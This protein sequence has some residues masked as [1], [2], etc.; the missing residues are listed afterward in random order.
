MNYKEILDSTRQQANP[1]REQHAFSKQRERA[2]ELDLCL[3]TG[4]RW[5]FPYSYKTAI[6]FDLSGTIMIYFTTHVVTIRG[7][8]LKPLYEALITHTLI[9]V[10]EATDEFTENLEDNTV[11][12]SLKVDEM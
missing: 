12:A 3:R 5:A 6:K 4:D 7:R 2:V 9:C 8:N 10:R 11:V 1:S